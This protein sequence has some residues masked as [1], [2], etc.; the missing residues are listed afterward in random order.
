MDG[1]ERRQQSDHHHDGEHEHLVVEERDPG[2]VEDVTDGRQPPKTTDDRIVGVRGLVDR[3]DA[4]TEVDEAPDREDVAGRDDEHME[5]IA[6]L[7][8]RLPVQRKGIRGA[9]GGQRQQEGGDSRKRSH[10]AHH[11]CDAAEALSVC[12]TVV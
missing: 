11:R 4:E 8:R 3:V 10:V 12:L 1:D 7:R 2:G 6:D 9:V 5:L